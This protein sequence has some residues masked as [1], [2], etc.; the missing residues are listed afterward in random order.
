MA[1]TSSAG[2]G[3][4]SQDKRVFSSLNGGVSWIQIATAPAAGIAFSLAVSPSAAVVLGTDRGID[5]LPRGDIA[6]QTATLAGGGPAGGFGY[7]GMTSGAQGVALPAD[8]S[9]GRV[10]LTFDGGQ[11]WKSFPLNGA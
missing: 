8:P 5:L 1:C 10:W 4:H 9:A 3:S 6:W 2:S 11:T 7:V